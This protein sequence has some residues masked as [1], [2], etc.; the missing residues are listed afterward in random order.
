MATQRP[1]A[2]ALTPSRRRQVAHALH[3]LNEQPLLAVRPPR[4]PADLD[5]GRRR[6][7]VLQDEAEG[8]LSEGHRAPVLSLLRT[9]AYRLASC[10]WEDPWAYG[11]V[12]WCEEAVAEDHRL[13]LLHTRPTDPFGESWRPAWSA[14]RT[15]WWIR[16]AQGAPSPVLCHGDRVMGL[17]HARV[18]RW[19]DA[20]TRLGEALD[21]GEWV[22]SV[23]LE[24]V[25]RPR[26]AEATRQLWH[27]VATGDAF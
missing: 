23:G 14:W 27:A 2:P 13:L 15:A 6:L 7:L 22:P 5:P 20:R 16:R 19:A 3:T 24:A 17:L 4:Q 12:A 26:M 18:E 25:D 8:L 9:E 1:V 10:S 21:R 11:L